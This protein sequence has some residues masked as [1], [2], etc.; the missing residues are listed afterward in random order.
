MHRKLEHVQDLQ[1]F[2]K[3]STDVKVKTISKGVIF[4]NITYKWNLKYDI[5]EL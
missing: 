2:W 5:D 4:Y 1:N 3:N